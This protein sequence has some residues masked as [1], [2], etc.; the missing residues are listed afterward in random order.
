MLVSLNSIR[1][2]LQVVK[3]EFYYPV[4]TETATDY[5]VCSKIL[6]FVVTRSKVHTRIILNSL[7]LEN[8]SKVVHSDLKLQWCRK[9]CSHHSKSSG[10]NSGRNKFRFIEHIQCIPISRSCR[11][12]SSGFGRFA[13]KTLVSRRCRGCLSISEK[14]R[15]CL[16]VFP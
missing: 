5:G 3:S 15:V 11:G 13:V 16:L 8:H 6:T 10:E 1:G 4:T 9:A 14:S 7:N 2:N 12:R